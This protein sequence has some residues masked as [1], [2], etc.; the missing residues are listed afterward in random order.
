MKTYVW[1]I[2]LYGSQTWTIAKGEQRRI[3]DFG[4]RYYRRMLKINCTDT[5]TIEEVLEKN[6]REMNFIEK[7]Q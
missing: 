3:D 1:S 2:M 7:Y 5:A 4:M 6:V